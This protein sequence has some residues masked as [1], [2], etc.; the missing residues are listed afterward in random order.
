VEDE[1]RPDESRSAG[2]KNLI[3]HAICGSPPA[4]K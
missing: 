2:D 4:S 3:T 1:V